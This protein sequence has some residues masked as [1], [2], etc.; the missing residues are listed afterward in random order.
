MNRT[1]RVWAHADA[2]FAEADRAFKEA[3]RIFRSMPP[4]G[5]GRQRMTGF[6]QLRFEARSGS[7][8]WRLLKKFLSMALGILFTGKA[9]LNF[10]DR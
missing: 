9:R 5:S 10:K 1:D 4:N 8:R 3:D 6:H 7:E 2:A